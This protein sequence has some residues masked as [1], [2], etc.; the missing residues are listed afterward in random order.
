MLAHAEA[1]NARLRA[2][3]PD[4]F[5]LDAQHQPHITLLQCFVARTDLE[6]VY[7]AVGGA[8]QAA[9]L[10]NMSLQAVRYGYT[11]GPGMGVAGIWVAVTPDLLQLQADIIAAVTPFMAATG[12][13]EAFT[14]NH[15]SAAYDAALID[16]VTHFVGKGAGAHFQPHV[17]T[18]LAPTA[19]LD[20][21]MAEPF[22]TFTF[23][24]ES[25]AVYQLG[26]FGTAARMLRRWEVA[27]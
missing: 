11:P 17:S 18:G 27:T 1:N 19:Y 20:A 22:E 12:P 15:N 25:A 16:Y 9:S 4:G 21:M 5:A 23:G 6:S 26:P 3:F 2:A 8:L 7:A 13:I 14:A 24:P 10:S